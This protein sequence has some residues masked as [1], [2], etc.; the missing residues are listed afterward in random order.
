MLFSAVDN[1]GF[2][3]GS[4]LPHNITSLLGVMDG[5]ASDLRTGLPL[6]MIEYHEPVRILFI[7]ESTTQLMLRMINRNQVVGRLCRNGWVR[8]A[9]STR[10]RAR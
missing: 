10:K 8:L 1:Q 2:G 5:A 4:K 7:I 3:C 6:Q 9:S